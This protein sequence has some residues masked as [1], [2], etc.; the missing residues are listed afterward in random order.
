MSQT[1]VISL[2]CR[3]NT[4]EAEM[5]REQL[6]H[7]E[8]TIVINTC[9]VTIEAER[10]T[11]QAIRRARRDNPDARLIV[12]GCAAQLNPAHY[13]AM[14]E[15]DKVLGN[16]E[17]LDPSAFLFG[18]EKD[19]IVVSD[20]MVATETAAHLIHGFDDRCR[21][22]VEIQQGC[23]HRCNFCIIP[24][25]RGP[26]RSVSFIRIVD[27]VRILTEQGFKEI[28]L[29]GVDI[30]SYGTDLPGKPSLGNLVRR[31]LTAVPELPRLRFSSLD[32]AAIDN[33]LYEILGE[34]QR[35]MPHFHLSIQ[36]LDDTIL[37]RMKRRHLFADVEAVVANAR[38]VRSDVVIGADLIAGFP[39]ETDQQFTNTLTRV[40][41]LGITHLHVFPYSERP[42]TPAARMPQTA[43]ETRK[44]R[45]RVLRET[46]AAALAQFMAD[47]VG[48]D[49]AVL[50]E[51]N[52]QGLSEHYVPVRING[53]TMPG[54]IQ[55]V[56]LTSAG[57]DHLVGMPA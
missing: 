2:G 55:A 18:H 24:F 13:G 44:E 21:A 7:L 41:E 57:T 47:Q 32:P 53:D 15:V 14:P 25:A 42:G 1:E 46:G 22:F 49:A 51:G 3:L 6:Q 33:T 56:T 9:A 8:N 20:I 30:C 28:V 34:E 37:K 17:K 45:A 40:N 36:A 52:D 50:V 16:R 35:V 29:T 31:L 48:T 26:C 11:R 12:T 4:F 10:Q 27:Q 54:K 43:P 38:S 23:D 39:T 19:P 5:M